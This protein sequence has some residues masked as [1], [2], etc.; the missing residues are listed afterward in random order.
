MDPTFPLAWIMIT[1]RTRLEAVIVGSTNQMGNLWMR[2]KKASIVLAILIGK[3]SDS[4]S[5]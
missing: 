3:H 2:K 4:Y 5:Y 1:N